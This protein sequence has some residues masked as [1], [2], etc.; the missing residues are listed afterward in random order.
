MHMHEWDLSTVFACKEQ[1]ACLHGD[2]SSRVREYKV[3]RVFAC[4]GSFHMLK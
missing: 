3:V 2:I 1:S 4:T